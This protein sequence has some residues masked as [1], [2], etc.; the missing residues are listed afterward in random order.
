[1]R[2][3]VRQPPAW[4]AASGRASRRWA[5]A[6]RRRSCSRSLKSTPRVPSC[7]GAMRI[8][9]FIHP[10]VGDRPDPRAPP[11]PRGDG[12]PRRRTEFPVDAGTAG[13]LP[14]ATTRCGRPDSL[15]LTPT[16]D[17]ARG[18]SVCASVHRGHP[19]GPRYGRAPTGNNVRTA[20]EAQRW[21]GRYAPATTRVVGDRTAR[22]PDTHPSPIEIPSPICA[23]RSPLAFMGDR[24]ID[25]P[26]PCVP[27]KNG[28]SISRSSVTTS[29]IQSPS[30][31]STRCEGAILPRRST[32]RFAV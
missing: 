22:A 7:H 18:R 19:I 13:T 9:A 26:V 14:H 30:H 29:A 23:S 6:L 12:R 21:A 27:Q 28:G 11:R 1:V 3:L 16:P 4:D 32:G 15:S 17:H 20:T 2:R 31:S 5:K 24:E 25:K 10:R 8:L